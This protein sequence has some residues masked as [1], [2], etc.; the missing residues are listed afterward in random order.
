MKTFAD[1]SYAIDDRVE[2]KGEGV[3]PFVFCTGW[4]LEIVRVESGEFYFLVDGSEVRPVSDR[5]GVFYPP[6]TIVRSC[7][8]NLK[9]S[10]V[11]VGT[12]EFLSGLPKEPFIF[13]TDFDRPFTSAADALTI[14]ASARGRQSI[15]VKSKPSLLSLQSKKLI[16]E[17]YFVFPSISRIAVRLNV[18]HEHLSRQFKRDFSMSPSEYLL[19]L[20]VA[21]ATFR[22]SVGEEIIDISHEVG[23]N[24]LSRFY[25]QF[26]KNT[27]TSPAQCR[28]M[29][30]QNGRS[31]SKNAKTGPP[32]AA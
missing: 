9:G 21:D 7:V 32:H 26:R 24:D 6:F 22:L 15:K 31:T 16:D 25:K 28:S 12:T 19:H 2:I 10:I 3:S 8:N 20:R 18:S 4:L 5:F 23:Y 27:R 11:G 30:T 13:E 29:L 17:N 1:G 14:I